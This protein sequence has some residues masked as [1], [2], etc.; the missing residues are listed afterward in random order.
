MIKMDIKGGKQLAQL[1]KQ[2]P[3]RI[4]RKIA[5]KALREGARPVIKEARARAPKGKTGLLK[6]SIRAYTAKGAKIRIGPSRDAWYA[7]FV[8]FG[9]SKM[10]A[11]PF[12]RPAFDRAGELVQISTKA[13]LKH[14]EREVALMRRR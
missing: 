8:E 13:V 14:L 12:M 1:M 2:V 4:E 3:L 5:K 9:T 11:R 10:T 6:K 7:H